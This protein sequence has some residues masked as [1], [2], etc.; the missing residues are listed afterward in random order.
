MRPKTGLNRRSRSQ[1]EGTAAVAPKLPSPS[2][3]QISPRGF[4]AHVHNIY[5]ASQ[6]DESMDVDEEDS[7]QPAPARRSRRKN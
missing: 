3:F 7:P 4:K 1:M 5:S 6:V 2:L